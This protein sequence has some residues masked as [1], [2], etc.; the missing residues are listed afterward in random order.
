MEDFLQNAVTQRF[1]HRFDM[2][3]KKIS[4]KSNAEFS[5]K[6]DVSPQTLNAILKGRRDLTIDFIAKCFTKLGI[7]PVLFFADLGEKL[8]IVDVEETFYG[9][10][11]GNINRIGG[12]NETPHFN[13]K[14]T[15][16]NVDPNVDL[17]V[18]PMDKRQNETAHNNTKDVTTD[19]FSTNQQLLS[20]IEN[21]KQSNALKDQTIAALQRAV[22]AYEQ[23]EKWR[24][25]HDE[26][27]KNRAESNKSA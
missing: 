3:K 5:R 19:N 8:I 12:Q 17:S 15:S 14:L 26:I 25:L 7:N 24:N 22:E 2:I 6:L 4:I 9:G 18:D 13:E 21:L 1:V 23:A 11:N 27:L 10:K 20:E 16:E